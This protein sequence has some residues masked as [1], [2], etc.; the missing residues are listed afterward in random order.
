VQEL[1]TGKQ[2]PTGRAGQQQQRQHQALLGLE[3][4]EA[5]PLTVIVN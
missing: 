5:A 3:L 1:H 4:I 2:W